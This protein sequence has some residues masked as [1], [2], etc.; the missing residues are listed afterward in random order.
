MSRREIYLVA[1]CGALALA[2]LVGAVVAIALAIAFDHRDR[3]R[4]GSLE[5]QV[6]VLC[7]RTTVSSVT[8]TPSGRTRVTTARGC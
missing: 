5:R 1:A 7:T 6:R 8:Q 2:A 3:D 4:I